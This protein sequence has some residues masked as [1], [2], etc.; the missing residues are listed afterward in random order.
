MDAP[1]SKSLP[2]NAYVPLASRVA[3]LEERLAAIS[4][5][6]SDLKRTLGED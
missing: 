2:E 6:L 1:D 5:E 4:R 3:A